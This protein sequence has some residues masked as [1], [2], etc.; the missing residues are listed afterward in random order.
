MSVALV[1]SSMK[2][3]KSLWL[4]G[5]VSVARITSYFIMCYPFA[6]PLALTAF[7]GYPLYAGFY[8]NLFINIF[9]HILCCIFAVAL[10]TFPL[11]Y[12]K[13]RWRQN[14]MMWFLV[15]PLQLSGPVLFFLL[16]NDQINSLSQPKETEDFL[17]ILGASS[18]IYAVIIFFIPHT[19][20]RSNSWRNAVFLWWTYTDSISTRSMSRIYD[21]GVV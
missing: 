19:R 16:F 8:A 3:Q 10:V 11:S 13:N 4:F 14:I 20:N 5:I 18:Y 15:V 21:A 7:W 12:F 2:Y 9:I 17:I 1:S 6:A